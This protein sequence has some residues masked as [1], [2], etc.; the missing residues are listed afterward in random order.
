MRS[1]E[2]RQPGR[3]GQPCV[4]ACSW[5]RVADMAEF[6]R[7]AHPDEEIR[8]AAEEACVD[9]SGMVEKLNTYR[10][11]ENAVVTQ[12]VPVLPLA[13]VVEEIVSGLAKERYLIIPGRTTRL[14]E[15]A[16]RWFP[17]LFRR[18]ADGKVARIHRGQ[19]TDR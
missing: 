6:L 18:I 9:V 13:T 12:T 19:A 1:I 2:D 10:T 8:R 11:R 5:R 17:S 4:N 7:V 16:N 15:L 14:A 3:C